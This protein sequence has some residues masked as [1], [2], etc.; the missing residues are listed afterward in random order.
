MLF[1]RIQASGL[2]LTIGSIGGSTVRNITFR[3]SYMHRTYKGIYLKF[4]GPGLITDVLYENITIFE[5]EQWPIWIGPAQQADSIDICKADPCSL[6]WP[7]VPFSE[8]NMPANASY[9]NITLRD[10]TVIDPE[11]TGVILGS[12]TNPMQN[13]VFDGVVFVNATSNYYVCENVATGDAIGGTTPVPTC[14]NMEY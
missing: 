6:C 1:E 14:F 5:P 7:D 13:V 3:D 10:I 11:E 2:G 12:A 8:C 4:R 9:V